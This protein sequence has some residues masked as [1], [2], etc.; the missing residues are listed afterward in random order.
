MK[1]MTLPEKITLCMAPLMAGT[2]AGLS[3]LIYFVYSLVGVTRFFTA[4]GRS[5]GH[6]AAFALIF[7]VIL[8][9]NVIL[10]L[11]TVASMSRVISNLESSS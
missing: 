7:G 1:K 2:C 4:A 10:S 11:V 9:A 8:A 3:T 6:V 5:G